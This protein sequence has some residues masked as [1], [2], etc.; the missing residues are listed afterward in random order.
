MS[1]LFISRPRGCGKQIELAAR[2][3]YAQ[4]SLAVGSQL[5]L[6]AVMVVR[7]ATTITEGD[8]DNQA[9]K[10]LQ[11]FIE[12]IEKRVRE[13]FS[14]DD[15]KTDLMKLLARIFID[16]TLLFIEENTIHV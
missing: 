4:Y 8:L 13:G 9:T 5:V 6:S 12:E 7:D 3:C 11:W 1:T 16:S 14:I 15:A 2:H 10:P